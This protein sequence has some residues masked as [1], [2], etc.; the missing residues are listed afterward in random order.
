MAKPLRRVMFFPA[1]MK[2]H[3]VHTARM[4]EWF[5]GDPSGSYEVHV[6]CHS[7]AQR[8]LPE[9]VVF[10]ANPEAA[11][12]AAYEEI[13]SAVSKA[14]SPGEALSIMIRKFDAPVLINS[15]RFAIG[16][17]REVR[18]DVC[19]YEHAWN[20]GNCFHSACRACG[21]PDLMLVAMARP[22]SA[23]QAS[24]LFKLAFTSPRAVIKVARIIMGSGREL[25]PA[26][27]GPVLPMSDGPVVMFPGAQ[28]LC[29]VPPEPNEIYTGPFS[30]LPLDLAGV[31][32]HKSPSKSP[33]SFSLG[34]ASVGGLREWLVTRRMGGEPIIYIAL[35]TLATPSADLLSRIVEALD[36][37]PW[38]VVWAL[39]D[40]HRKYLPRARQLSSEQWQIHS[41][42]PQVA[43]FQAHLVDCFISHCGGSSTTEAMSNGIPMVCLPFFG[44]Q[45]DWARS[46]AGHLKAGVQVDKD[47]AS[48][49][50][51]RLAVTR[52][53]GDGTFAQRAARVSEEMVLNATKRLRHLGIEFEGV[54]RAGLPVAAAVIEAV[55]QNKDPM[56]VL[57]PE[58]RPARR[59]PASSP[60]ARLA[61]CCGG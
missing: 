29:E 56:D 55:A 43:L 36:G 32:G 61:W 4:S 30:P 48:A 5:L 50:D 14:R 38:S 58:L 6:C 31:D 10:H 35:G 40:A 42:L 19:M 22:E 9:G 52:V 53:A 26:I 49:A 12:M 34:L 18:P 33:S 37:G 46:I 24:T 2:G 54:R 39:P 8:H 13:F 1:P 15:V 11:G 28:V 27:G 45:F 59:L 51:I 16:K 23:L 47:A 57:P 7:E 20:L 60:L 21:V 25:R 17:M 41:F 3:L 44:D